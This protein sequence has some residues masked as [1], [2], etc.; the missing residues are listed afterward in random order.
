MYVRCV[1]NK[2]YVAYKDQPAPEEELVTLTIGKVYKALPQTPDEQRLGELR[3]IDNEGE[4]YIYPADY[5]EP[6]L[7]NGSQ[8]TES[9]T[10]HLDQYL[11]NILHAEALAA[12][13]SVSALLREWAEERLDLPAAA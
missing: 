6:F 13:K 8:L 2:A 7:P 11:K 10:V 3:V 4:D 5:F 12:N 1:K 9:V